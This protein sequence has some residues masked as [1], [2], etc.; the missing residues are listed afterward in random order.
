MPFSKKPVDVLPHQAARLTRFK[1]IMRRFLP[2]IAAVL[3]PLACLQAAAPPRDKDIQFNRDIRTLLSDNCLSCH[4]PDSVARKAK[5]RLDTKAGMFG[6]TKGEGPVVKPGKPDQSAL[7]TRINSKDEDE[8]MPPLKSHKV[9]KPDQKELLKKWILA[10]APWQD[11]WAFIKPERPATPRVKNPRWVGNPIDAFVLSQLEARGLKPAPEAD[12]HTL[13]RRVTLDLTGLPPTTEEV[14][15]FVS[16]KSPDAYNSLVKRLLASP[17]YGE[18][19]ARYWLDAARYADT[20]GLHFDNY[21]EMWPYRDWVI[22]AFNSNQPFDQ[23]T[24]EQIA[25]DL[26]ENPSQDQLVATGFHRCNMTTNEGGTIEEENLAIYANDRVST[27]S[28][29]WLGLTAGCAACHDHKFD[30]ITTRDFYSMA[31]FFRNTTQKGL[32]GNIRDTLP[33]ITVI[34]NPMDQARWKE[35]P[36]KIEAAKSGIATVRKDANPAF[37]NWV[38]ALKPEDIERELSSKDLTFHAELDDSQTNIITARVG[39]MTN[40]FQ[41]QGQ[42]TILTN[43]GKIGPAPQFPA[44]ATVAFPQAGDFDHGQPFSYGTWSYIP[45]GPRV[46]GLAMLG[47]MDEKN[48]HRGWDLWMQQDVFAVHIVNTWPDNAIKVRTVKRAVKR[49]RW[50]HVFVT[51]NGSGRPE[52]IHIYVDGEKQEIEA[53]N[54]KGVTGS[55]RTT[56]PLTLAQRS[57]GG[58][59]F[60]SLALQDVRIYN[61]ELADAEVGALFNFSG[62]AKQLATPL[63][64]WKPEQRDS[65]FEYYLTTRS[66]PFK[67]AQSGVAALEQEREGLRLKYP[68]TH[69]QQEKKD[70]MPM[71]A[72]LIRGQYDKPGDKVEAA[73]FAALNPLPEGAPRNRL[74]LAK[75]LVDRNNPLTARVT[76][77]RYWQEV[78]GTGLVKTTDDFGVMGENPSNPALLDWLATEFMESGWDVKHMFTL[79]LMSSTY[80]QSAEVTDAK[81]EKDPANRLLSRGPRYRMDAE[82]IRDYALATGG[83]LSQKV[84]GPSVK[85]YQPDGVWEAVAMPESNTRYYKRD[86]GEALYRRSLYTFWKRAAPPASMEILNAPSRE[87]SCTRRERTNTP[88]Q[89]LATLNDPQFIEAARLLAENALKSSANDGEKALGFTIER[90]VGR[91]L[92]S[93]ELSIVRGTLKEMESYYSGQPEEAAK[94]IKV[95]ASVADP[96]LPVPQLA[97]LTMVANQLL[98]LDEVLTK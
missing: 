24:V 64:K 76:V 98:N 5:L 6:E 21:R 29:V 38:A 30:P 93:K 91:P 67:K 88:L 11:H 54:K 39:G 26:F 97:A 60:D 25:G 57:T 81:R 73:T 37:T 75:W 1:A 3:T 70:S 82:M 68:V 89:A 44:G 34:D 72:I 85:P 59:H 33:S 95:G 9:L 47:R 78:F 46:E 23:F 63:A 52:G 8:V 42:P 41:A 45:A 17:R 79:M 2:L 7:W 20:H 77:N 50:Q 22:R 58:A 62:L 80:R 92:S 31:A 4:G 35:L 40:T 43:A 74:G 19:R 71:A 32:D 56:V 61:R 14:A 87:V 28:G 15:A 83:S 53:E 13:I 36:A 12:R 27:T 69:I 48:G 10:G 90:V 66:E 16:D 96:K 84:G 55:I 65:L 86:Q 18:H 49:G 94:L 51:Y